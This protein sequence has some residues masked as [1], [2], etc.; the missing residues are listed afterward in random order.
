MNL[1]EVSAPT[2]LVIDDH[3]LFRS[4]LKMILKS[5]FMQAQVQEASSVEEVLGDAQARPD[6]V[7][8]DVRLNGLSGI[9]SIALLHRR[10]PGVPVIMLSSDNST[11]TIRQAQERG[12]ARFVSKA[13]SSADILQAI[14]SVFMAQP[15][16]QGL[17]AAVQD[18]VPLKLTPR[19][20][21][22]LH[23]LSQG[24]SNKTIAKKLDLSENTVRGHVQSVMGLLDSTS[25][26]EA[27]FKARIQGLIH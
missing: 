12:A 7:L 21:E 26:S 25:R 22:V 24:L 20:S 11:H 23:F 2:I 13:D 15:L 4:G 19:Q 5:E 27:V 8:L 9:E 6:V 18:S 14:R 1:L 16:S 3:L 17:S 10:W